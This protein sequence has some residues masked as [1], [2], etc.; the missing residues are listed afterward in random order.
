MIVGT[1]K[2]EAFETAA[3]VC[4]VSRTGILSDPWA[5]L[6]SYASDI[7]D[8]LAPSPLE[9]THVSLIAPYGNHVL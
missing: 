5:D 6:A 1:S 3:Y 9:H 2:P 7:R 8:A 4:L